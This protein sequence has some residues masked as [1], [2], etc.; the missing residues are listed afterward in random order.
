[1]SLAVIKELEVKD[2]DKKT[3]QDLWE[4]YNS[5]LVKKSNTSLINK[6]KEYLFNWKT[7]FNPSPKQQVFRGLIAEILND[8]VVIAFE[9]TIDDRREYY[10]L[11]PE[12]FNFPISEGDLVD[13]ILEDFGNNTYRFEPMQ[14]KKQYYFEKKEK[15]L[16]KDLL[17]S[18]NEEDDF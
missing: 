17:N 12:K 13:F 9:N 6:A 1:M 2:K 3:T 4:N 5:C 7:H 18:F 8:K 10:F 11:P 16:I 15:T 14:Y